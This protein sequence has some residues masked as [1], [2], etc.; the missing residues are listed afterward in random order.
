MKEEEKRRREL[1]TEDG[2][3]KRKLEKL[4]ELKRKV[5][6][7]RKEQQGL[8]DKLKLTEEEK[9]IK[10][11]EYERQVASASFKENLPQ[12]QKQLLQELEGLENAVY[13]LDNKQ[14]DWQEK[15][16]NITELV[17]THTHMM[18]DLLKFIVLCVFFSK[19]LKTKSTTPMI[20]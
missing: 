11:A 16:N 15:I 13:E 7:M 1:D 2:E 12:V 5:V 17:I 8:N 20:W 4:D 18:F 19:S 3:L 10:E 6:A 9:A 14:V